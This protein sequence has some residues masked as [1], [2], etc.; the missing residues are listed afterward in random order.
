MVSLSLFAFSACTGQKKAT[1]PTPKTG[2]EATPV[3]PGEPGGAEP[4]ERARS[5]RPS[6]C[7]FAQPDVRGKVEEIEGGA[8]ITFTGGPERVGELRTAAGEMAALYEQ[9]AEMRAM[10]PQAGRKVK[11]G[12]RGM[13]RGRRGMHG[14]GMRAGGM[15]MGM[16]MGGMAMPPAEVNVSEVGSGVRIELVAEEREDVPAVRNRVFRMYQ[17][18]RA[19]ACAPMIGMCPFG[20]P[21]VKAEATDIEG[22]TAISFT[23]DPEYVPL[24]RA[25]AEDMVSMHYA[26]Q[27]E[28]EGRASPGMM[29]GMGPMAGMRGMV[30]ADVR[31]EDVRGGVRMVVTARQSEDVPELREQVFRHL[32]RMRGARC[33]A[34]MGRRP[35]EET[36][37]GTE[38]ELE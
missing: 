30:P 18:M 33:G 37:T 27:R 23:A 20:S 6:V 8:A 21:D 34:G 15:G 3:E 10:T 31:V 17:H 29:R 19:G 32:A 14:R 26:R 12:Q 11:R 13:M 36:E 5:P 1:P 7:P 16:G 9:A 2:A 38:T 35:M 4:A 28:K 25:A 24:L 22:G